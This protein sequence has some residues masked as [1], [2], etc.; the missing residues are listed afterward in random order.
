[1]ATFMSIALNNA[2]TYS[3]LNAANEN[4]LKQK[5]EIEDKN[6]D[7]LDSI[8]YARRIQKSLLPTE[9][10]IERNLNKFNKD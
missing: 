6:K 4:I 7:I 1:M 3:Q 10:Y 2:D 9:I 5:K 8:T